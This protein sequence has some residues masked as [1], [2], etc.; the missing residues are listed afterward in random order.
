MSILSKLFRLNG[1]L[2]NQAPSPYS[3]YLDIL[4]QWPTAPSLASMWMTVFDLQSVPALMNDPAFQVGY[5]DSGDFQSWEVSQHTVDFLISKENQSTS[6]NLMGCVFAQEVSVPGETL[7]ANQ[8]SLSW[9]GFQTPWTIKSRSNLDKLK[10]TFLET[11]A[12]F[13]DLVIRPWLVLTSHYGLVARSQN[14][15]KNV[16]CRFVDVIQFAKTSAYKP[17]TINKL[18][19]YYDVVP[20]TLDSMTLSRSEEGLRRRNVSF[21]YN[22]YSVMETGTVNMIKR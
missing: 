9:G 19:R 11:N 12:S 13:C 1:V 8:E 6:E 2:L 14:S 15:P 20:V 5:L 16:K 7:S 17:A 18:I 22:G 21:V 10:M 3:Y 4:S